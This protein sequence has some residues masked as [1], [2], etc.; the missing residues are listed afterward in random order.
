MISFKKEYFFIFF[1]GLLT[2]AIFSYFSFLIKP[3]FFFKKSDFSC[4][5]LKK[6]GK[7]TEDRVKSVVDGDTLLMEGG[8][9]VRILGINADEK[10][11]KCYLPAKKRL[12][13]LVLEKKVL[14][15]KEK[16]DKDE[17]CRYLRNVFLNGENIGLLLLKEGLVV[18]FFVENLKNKEEI[19]KIE[20]EAKE[21]KIGCQ[22]QEKEEIFVPVCQAKNFLK[23][24]ITTEGR[25]VS[26]F[27]SK[28]N[29]VFLNLEKPYPQQCLT[30]V[31]FSGY[32]SKFPFKPDKF[33]LNKRVR[34]KGEIQEYEGKPE[35]IIKKID[36]IKVID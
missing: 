5:G 24:E 10:E 16:E 11:E 3:D 19:L 25:V 12:E 6:I 26:T 4:P 20:N 34:I 28:N 2:G 13:D 21:K 22:W 30:A 17:Y 9:Y 7:K 18:S 36:Q 27:R 23:K 29:N 32:L 14:L 8:Y 35:V 1:L 33:Y 15:K 31:I